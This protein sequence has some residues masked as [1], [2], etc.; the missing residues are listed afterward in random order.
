MARGERR[1]LGFGSGAGFTLVEV[2]VVIAILGVLIGLL[3]PAIQAARESSRRRQCA[4]NLH[5]VALA[6]LQY[7][8]ARKSFPPALI[9]DP[10]DN[11]AT[12]VHF[13]FNWA[14]LT[15]EFMDYAG[16]EHA[17]DL[18]GYVNDPGTS[19]D[20]TVARCTLISGMLCPS[21]SGQPGLLRRRHQRRRRLGPRKLRGQR[22]LRPHGLRRDGQLGHRSA[23]PLGCQGP[24]VYGV[25]GSS[26]PGRHGSQQLHD[27]AGGSDRWR[28]DDLPGRG[29]PRRG[30]EH[31]SRGTWAMGAAGASVVSYY[32]WGGKDNGPNCCTG[33]AD[34]VMGAAGFNGGLDG[35]DCMRATDGPSEQATFRSLHPGGVNVAMV[36]AS[37]HFISDTIRTGGIDAPLSDYAGSDGAR[38]LARARLGRHAAAG[39][40]PIDSQPRRT[41]RGRGRCRPVAAGRASLGVGSRTGVSRGWQ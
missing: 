13:H 24:G 28:G 19:N 32:G 21:D 12:T 1:F 39:L 30:V 25:G 29:D 11:P 40:G 3:L 6:L 22:R 34:S 4:S 33:E 9:T 20:N 26:G 31:G 18:N 5:Q 14:I 8:H 27:A 38:G 15:L 10:G 17:F 7:E 37:V 35:N 2:L 41:E 23:G 36:D 16:L